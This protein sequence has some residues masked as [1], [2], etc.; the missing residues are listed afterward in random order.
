MGGKRLC[1]QNDAPLRSHRPVLNRLAML[2]ALERMA[3]SPRCEGHLIDEVRRTLKKPPPFAVLHR[4]FK[5]RQYGPL[6]G[7]VFVV[8]HP[9]THKDTTHPARRISTQ[10]FPT[11][12]GN[13]STNIAAPRSYR[14]LP[15]LQRLTA[16]DGVFTPTHIKRLPWSASDSMLITLLAGGFLSQHH[17]PLGAPS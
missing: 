17:I 2:E 6:T 3:G 11:L 12:L 7:N 5:P 9:A 8:A 1:R 13:S 4:S 14:D 10:S 15:Y 16:S